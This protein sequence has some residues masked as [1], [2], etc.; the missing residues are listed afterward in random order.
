VGTV[1][2]GTWSPTLERAVAMAYVDAPA[3]AGGSLEVEVRERAV[4]ARLVQLP[5]YRRPAP[6]SAAATG[7]G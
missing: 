2:S 3:A 6:K 4:A 1:T 5:F 7:A